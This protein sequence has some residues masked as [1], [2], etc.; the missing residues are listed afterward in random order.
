[1]KFETPEEE[2]TMDDPVGSPDEVV[3]RDAPFG[4]MLRRRRV[5]MTVVVAG[6]AAAVILMR[7][8]GGGPAA[9]M[10]DAALDNRIDGFLGESDRDGRTVRADAS[11]LGRMLDTGTRDWQVPLADLSCNPFTVSDAHHAP[12][13]AEG[14]H[15]GTGAMERALHRR[16][17]SMEVSMVMS[18]TVTV[19]L[20]DG[21]RMPLGEQ[22]R[23]D[24]DYL[25]TLISV[26][27][28]ALE[29]EL[30]GAGSD[31]VVRGAVPIAPRDH[32]E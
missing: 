5:L 10:A 28:H 27:D 13:P 3:H 16:L 11:D 8:L 9:A 14:G 21:I 12:I 4:S 26:G 22:V 18:G 6:G 7:M 15:G 17:A 2:L 23:T 31:F 30:T 24:D 19:A 29:L 1:M 25:A 32:K 20:V